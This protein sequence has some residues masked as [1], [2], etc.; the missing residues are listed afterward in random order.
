MALAEATHHSAPRRQMTARAG[1]GA[2]DVLYGRVPE[3]ALPQAAGARYFAMD[4]GEDVGEAPAAGRPA[5]LFEVLPQE[6]VG[7]VPV[8]PLLHAFVPQMVEQLVDILAP[9]DFRV[10]E[11]VIEVP[12]IVCPPCAAHTVLRAPQTADQL[13]EVPTI[14]SYSSLLQRTMEQNVAIPVPGRGGRA[15]WSSRFSS[16][17]GFNRD[18]FISET[19]F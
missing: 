17:T 18:A 3:D 19:H 5:P 1:G 10:A 8:V 6:R 13:V 12:K 16:R 7:P 15:F 4:A 9:L 2:R 14:I 11:Q